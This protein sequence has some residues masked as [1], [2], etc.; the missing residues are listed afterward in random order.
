MNTFL[1]YET[2]VKTK[3]K[4]EIKDYLG[5]NENGYTAYPNLKDKMK[6]VLTGIYAYVKK[7]NRELSY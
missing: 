7:P 1:L 4:N 6:V 2:W 5:F 3:I